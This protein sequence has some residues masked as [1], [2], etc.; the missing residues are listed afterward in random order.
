MRTDELDFTLPPEL[1]AQDPPP[2]RT[3]SRLLHYRRDDRSIAHRHFTALPSLLRKGDLL[4][5]ND[6]KVLP[7]RFM[8]RKA[9]G[10]RV[11]GLFLKELEP[12][13]WNVLL[14][15]LGNVHGTS[16]HFEDEPALS[17]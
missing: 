5:L 6:A 14:K 8:L 17:A 9:T 15:N 2:E 11:E 12:G 7:A 16:M 1:I 10:G 4:V 3:A 13:K